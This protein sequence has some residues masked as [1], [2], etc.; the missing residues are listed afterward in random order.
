LISLRKSQSAYERP[1]CSVTVSVN[2]AVPEG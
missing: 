2:S 1:P